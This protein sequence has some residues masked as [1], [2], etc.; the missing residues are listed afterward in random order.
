MP[1]KVPPSMIKTFDVVFEPCF[2]AP[3]PEAPAVG[4]VKS[5]PP[6]IIPPIISVS[7]DSFNIQGPVELLVNL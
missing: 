7:P 6:V 2:T 4:D 3:P 1:T 5:L